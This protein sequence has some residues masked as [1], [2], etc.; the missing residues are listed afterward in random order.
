MVSPWL[1]THGERR[2]GLLDRPARLQERGEIRAGAQPWNAQLDIPGAGLP[3]PV[4]VAVALRQTVRRLLAVIRAGPG[5]VRRRSR[6]SR[7]AGR[8][9]RS[10]RRLNR[11][12]TAPAGQGLCSGQASGRSQPCIRRLCCGIRAAARLDEVRRRSGPNQWHALLCA[13]V[14]TGCPDCRV[15]VRS[16]SP[17]VAPHRLDAGRERPACPVRPG[18]PGSSRRVGS[19]PRRPAPCGS[20]ARPRRPSRA[21]SPACARASRRRAGGTAVR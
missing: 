11:V 19:A 20:P 7:A 5:A 13:P 14:Q 17:H 6:S 10:G 16:P 15:A 2:Q 12:W 18:W 1:E 4:P 21:F 8:R 9:R 3:L